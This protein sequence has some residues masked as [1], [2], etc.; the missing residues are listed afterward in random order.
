[1]RSKVLSATAARR[2][3]GRTLETVQRFGKLKSNAEISDVYTSI[4]KVFAQ[5]LVTRIHCGA[6]TRAQS[7]AA[8]VSKIPRSTIAGFVCI[9]ESDVG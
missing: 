1:V 8:E 9:L 6:R 7:G 5:N 3:I 2:T 4:K